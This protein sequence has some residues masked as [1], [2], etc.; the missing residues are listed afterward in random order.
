LLSELYLKFNKLPNN[1]GVDDL[2]EGDY[3]VSNYSG[4]GVAVEPFKVWIRGSPM[5][6]ISFFLDED[7]TRLVGS[8]YELVTLA[9]QYEDRIYGESIVSIRERVY[10]PFDAV[11]DNAP[12]ELDAN[13]PLYRGAHKFVTYR[14][15]D[16]IPADKATNAG[17]AKSYVSEHQRTALVH[18]YRGL[19]GTYVL[20]AAGSVT[21]QKFAGIAVPWQVTPS[22]IKLDEGDTPS[23]KVSDFPGVLPT[24]NTTGD[25]TF[26]P[27][28]KDAK[29]RNYDTP[30]NLDQQLLANNIYPQFGLN[31]S[32]VASG[33]VRATTA[34]QAIIGTIS[35][36][37]LDGFKKLVQWRLGT[38]PRPF[39]KDSA[40]SKPRKPDEYC[41]DPGMWKRI[42]KPFVINLTPYGHAKRFYLGRAFITITEDGGII[43]QDAYGSQITMSGGNIQLSAEH[44]IIRQSGRN[45]T[46][47]VGRDFSVLAARH[48]ELLA[49][50]GQACLACSGTMSV[51]GGLDK[52]HGVNIVS[53]GSRSEEYGI[54]TS[55]DAGGV[56]IVSEGDVRL[57]GNSLTCNARNGII[58]L[59]TPVG[60]IAK[61]GGYMLSMNSKGMY[62]N[63]GVP[64][65]T[66]KGGVLI[67]PSGCVLPSTSVY[68]NLSAVTQSWLRS[69]VINQIPDTVGDKNPGLTF[70]M[71]YTVKYGQSVMEY[72]WKNLSGNYTI[73][74]GFLI[75]SHFYNVEHDNYQLAGAAWQQRITDY[76]D[77]AS[78]LQS[79]TKLGTLGFTNVRS[80]SPGLNVAIAGTS[81]TTGPS[82]WQDTTPALVT[83]P[84]YI[85]Y[86]PRGI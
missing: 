50:E 1:G 59:D 27:P 35:T 67:S 44:D 54:E 63:Q 62:F 84:V 42:P 38:R 71:Q 80:P 28:D 51:I 68:G 74:P 8:N 21:L 30:A 2:T 3:L 58:G 31:N 24:G 36:Q 72:Y 79:T 20:T 81:F 34:C 65:Q 11:Y 29:P 16:N 66:G 32:T 64:F 85:R 43:L 22:L 25:A 78:A 33:L 4:G 53:Y 60:V 12:Q 46:A 19:D 69:P 7:L 17:D 13:G 52:K 9:E 40:E 10:Y 15:K 47:F 56:T 73:R 57:S 41:S 49:K 5:S 39:F 45:D 77:G 70:L 76:A 75:N 14:A 37:G 48:V 61:T 82:D 6:G 86:L 55:G 26:F 23:D 83:D 18:E